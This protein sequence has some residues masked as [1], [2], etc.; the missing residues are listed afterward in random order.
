VAVL[1]S[2]CGFI[3]EWVPLNARAR[4]L[5]LCRTDGGFTATRAKD[6]R[7]FFGVPADRNIACPRGTLVSPR[8]A[9][10]TS[11]E[12]QCSVTGFSDFV[13]RTSSRFVARE[14]VR[15]A[16]ARV[17]T[18]HV[19]DELEFEGS[20]RGRAVRETWRRASDGLLV[21]QRYREQSVLDTHVGDVRLSDSYE[22]ELSSLE[23]RT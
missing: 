2:K 9:R 21:K 19:R 6:L 23:P 3:E 7:S 1:G 12:S 8:T 14:A 10:V 22:L 4:E 17:A 15:V 5:A 18:V 20:T 16:G 13:A 11:W